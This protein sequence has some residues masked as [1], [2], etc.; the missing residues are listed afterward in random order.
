VYVSIGVSLALGLLHGFVPVVAQWPLLKPAHAWLNLVGFVGIVVAATYVHLMPT[1]LGARIVEGR[2][3]RAA[4]G[5]LAAGVALVSGGFALGS[6]VVVRV[7]AVMALAGAAAVPVSVV[8]AIRQPGRGRWTTALG[9]HRFVS[10]SMVASAAWFM[11][12]I[13]GAS[14]L[15]LVHGASPAAWSLAMVGVPLVIGGVVQ[16]IVAAATHLRPTGAA[17]DVATRARDRLG[18]VARSRVIVYQIATAGLWM[19]VAWPPADAAPPLAA[20]LLVLVL[21]VALAPLATGL[22]E[23]VRQA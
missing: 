3:P 13:V 11:V 20:V 19:T 7:G 5:G 4:I 22:A 15:V 1:V 8:A 14:L 12:G 6:D 2:L 16:A 10:W 21:T 23:R 18:R 17:V 9:W